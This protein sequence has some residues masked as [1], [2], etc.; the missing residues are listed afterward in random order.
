MKK[1]FI[2]SVILFALMSMSQTLQAQTNKT[3]GKRATTVVEQPTDTIAAVTAKAQA[4]DADAQNLL[5]EWYFSGRDS[6]LQDY[7]AAVKWWIA[8]GKQNHAA[9]IGHLG[10]C[11]QFGLGVDADSTRAA[12]LYERAIRAGNAAVLPAQLALSD[13]GNVF[14]SYFAAYCLLKGIGCDKDWKKAAH[15]YENIASRGNVA[16][17]REAA[18]LYAGNRAYKEAMDWFVK[19]G[20]AKDMVSEFY[21]GKYLTDGKGCT[22]DTAK[23]FVYLLRAAE[24]GH[25]AAQYETGKAYNE[26]TG[27]GKDDVRAY[28]WFEQASLQGNVHAMWNRAMCLKNGTG[29]GVDY[30]TSIYWLA[31]AAEKGYHNKAKALVSGKQPGWQD[32]PYIEYLYGMQQYAQGNYEAA[33]KLFKNVAKA[34]VQAGEVMLQ[35]CQLGQTTDLR[36][37][38]RIANALSRMDAPQARMEWAKLCFQ[39]RGMEKDMDKAVK[40]MNT[41]AEQGYAPAQCWLGDHYYEGNG[42]EKNLT[43]AVKYYLRAELSHQL[44]HQSAQ[45][46]ATCYR[47]GAGML[48]ANSDHAA[49]I[50]KEY[51]DADLLNGLFKRIL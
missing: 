31:R 33:A 47:E 39:G 13:S 43:V 24:K 34:K 3:K 9:A 16:A 46:L 4:G 30:E 7:K 50:E 14:S 15:C 19:G 1:Y 44:T 20:E 28:Y 35:L 40:I 41:L 26:G 45:R 23:G 25:A 36:T 29:T 37:E 22:A 27:T 2:L 38:K 18:L 51:A 10:Y 5:G 21:Y 42:V 49:A 48:K 17:V 8:A 6:L 32:S 12:Q 11:H